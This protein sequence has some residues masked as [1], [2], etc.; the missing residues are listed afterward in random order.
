M[1]AVLAVGT[2]VA[3]AFAGNVTVGRFYT[4]LAQ[5]KHLV[6]VDVAS[7][8]A[9][10]RGA[11]VNLPKLAL[12]K[13]LTEGDMTAISNALGV[14]V[15]T[16]RPSQPISETQLN[17]FMA[18]FG[19]QI[20]ARTDRAGI[21][22][23]INSQAAIPVRAAT[24]MARRRG[25]ASRH[26]RAAIKPSLPIRDFEKRHR[27]RDGVSFALAIDAA[28]G[29]IAIGLVPTH[30]GRSGLSSSCC[31]SR[32]APPDSS[33]RSS[34]CG[35]SR[36][37][38][39]RRRT[40]SSAV[41][42]TFMGGL[43]LGSY[44]AGRRADRWTDPPL[45]DL[46]KARARDHR[47]TPRRSRGF[48]IAAAVLL[49]LAWKLG[50]DRHFALLGT[51]Q[52]HRDRDPDPSG[53]DADGRDASRPRPASRRTG[54]RASAPASERSTPS[55]RFGAVVGTIA[56]AFVAL[57]ALGM[58]RTLLANLAAQRA[59]SARRLDGSDDAPTEVGRATPP[60]TVPTGRAEPVALAD[61]GLAFAASGFAR[62][63]PGGGLD[64]RPGARARA[65]PSTRTRRC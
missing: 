33:I 4:E 36:S 37:S 59:S 10:L 49:E 48:S 32:R 13:S 43:A 25:T 63:G 38:S 1:I 58:R 27:H 20:G 19:G 23:T 7:A 9:S 40:P 15:T 12:D 30:R 35:S 16:E 61:V 45:R 52:V 29:V 14:T 56:A 60:Q 51:R 28:D 42:S 64:A 53:H 50:A 46:R 18:S 2:V 6:A 41:L 34:G 55:T 8:E 3:P 65:A 54:P 11:G 24:A 47:P 22:V 62:D 26:D 39:A 17:T 44:W 57:P 31:F 5:A 21:P